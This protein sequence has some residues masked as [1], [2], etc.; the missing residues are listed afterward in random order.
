MEEGA[1]GKAS[2]LFP[3]FGGISVI[4]AGIAS[5]RLGRGGRAALILV[6]LL[7]SIPA[8]LAFG[9]ANLGHSVPLAV[10]A[11]GLI[12]FVLIGPYSFLGGAIALDFGGKR[13]SATACGWIDGIGYLGGVFA[14]KGIGAIA[15]HSGWGTA[16]TVLAGIAAV[17]CLFAAFYWWMQT[18]K[19][20]VSSRDVI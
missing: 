9:F 4:L 16:F 3:L 7:L 14:G 15:E 12:A 13:G 20:P 17:S 6:G 10:A 11:L 5:D 18:R 2:S 8:L 1:A 19:A